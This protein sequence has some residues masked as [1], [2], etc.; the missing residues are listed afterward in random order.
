MFT[1]GFS[2]PSKSCT[3]ND[4]DDLVENNLPSSSAKKESKLAMAEIN[5][6]LMEYHAVKLKVTTGSSDLYFLRNTMSW[7]KRQWAC[8]I[9]E[10]LVIGPDNPLALITKWGPIEGMVQERVAHL[11]TLELPVKVPIFVGLECLVV[12]DSIPVVLAADAYRSS[13]DGIVSVNSP[14]PVFSCEKYCA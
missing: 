12:A 7:P 6:L 2:G 10:G 4:L 11:K 14:S 13:L 3:D 8:S 1:D 9:H 5:K